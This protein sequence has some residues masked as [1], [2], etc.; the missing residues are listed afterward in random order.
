MRVI[1][2]LLRSVR[3]TVWG[4]FFVEVVKMVVME[5]MK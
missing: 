3:I 4:I 5:R 1:V 2:A